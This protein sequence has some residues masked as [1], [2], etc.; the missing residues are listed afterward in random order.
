MGGSKILFGTR[1]ILICKSNQFRSFGNREPVI[2][3]EI[4]GEGRKIGHVPEHE[5]VGIIP[6]SCCA[7]ILCEVE[8]C[9][10]TRIQII[11]E[12][13][14]LPFHDRWKHFPGCNLH[15]DTLRIMNKLLHTERK[16]AGE[17]GMLWQL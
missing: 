2:F 9:I 1:K 13:C 16:A 10:S 15:I 17:V 6:C 11:G 12:I 5:V 4:P 7:F 14:S 3:T 8:L